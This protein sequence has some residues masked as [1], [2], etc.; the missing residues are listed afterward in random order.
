MIAGASIGSAE[1][2]G[3]SASSHDLQAGQKVYEATCFVCHGK[4]GKGALPG[5]PDMTSKK[6]RL[7]QDDALLLKHATEGYQ[8][9]GSM[10]AMP[11]KGGNPS[12]TEK[13]MKNVIAYMKANFLPDKKQK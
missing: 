5:V 9:K 1:T 12:L 8:S 3:A 10:M 11:A 6:S 13:D 4:D 7:K 2:G